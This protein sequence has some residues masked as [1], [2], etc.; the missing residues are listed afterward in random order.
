MKLFPKSQQFFD[1]F[2]KAANN[3]LI[4]AKLLDDFF[5]DP[6][7]WAT[8]VKKIEDVEH[9][10]DRITHDTI[11][12]L[13]KTF[14][15]PLDRE[16][17]HGLISEID[18]ILDLIY[19][20]ANRMVYYKV[21]APNADMKAVVK[22][23][24]QAVEEVAKA[25]LRLRNMKKPEMILAQ[26][27]EINRLE[28]EADEALRFAISNLFERE[29]DPIKLIKEKEILEMLESATDRCEDVAN[30]IEGIVLKNV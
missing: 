25:V 18:D 15:T 19:G 24:V 9:E 3:A 28:N 30:V 21:P 12:M 6:S 2:E 26:C 20:T 13:N 11:E 5:S 22:I 17:I 1:F 14:I 7:T 4:G 27:I 8:Q 10:G 29:K 16:D 23:L